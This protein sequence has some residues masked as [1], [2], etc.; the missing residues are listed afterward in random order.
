M[1]ARKTFSQACYE[2]TLVLKAQGH[3]AISARAIADE[4]LSARAS[5]AI[6]GDVKKKLGVISRRYSE[7]YGIRPVLVNGAFFEKAHGKPVARTADGERP[8]TPAEARRFLAIGGVNGAVGLWFPEGIDDP[9]EIASR[10]IRLASGGGKV[11]I[12]LDE[13]A[14]AY[15]NGRLSDAAR[16]EITSQTPSVP[17]ELSEVPKALT[18][19]RWWGRDV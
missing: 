12:V 2:A 11:E 8:W 9:L 14:T 16:R 13:A 6:I 5:R 15:Q 1:M 17:L 4:C 18:A 10:E 7:D 3:R 19:G